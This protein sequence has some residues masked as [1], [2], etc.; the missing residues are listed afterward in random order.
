MAASR[1]MV[2]PMFRMF[3]RDLPESEYLLDVDGMIEEAAAFDY[4]AME[5]DVI[6]ASWVPSYCRRRTCRVGLAALNTRQ[7]LRFPQ[8]KCWEVVKKRQHEGTRR[9]N[10]SSPTPRPKLPPRPGDDRHR[11]DRI[12]R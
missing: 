4:G 5:P 10:T 3:Y 12:H 6:A 2:A 9:Q 11:R 8:R 1:R 7:V